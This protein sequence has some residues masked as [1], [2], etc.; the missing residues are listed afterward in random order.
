MFNVTTGYF[1]S[2]RAFDSMAD[3]DL[4]SPDNIAR[5]K[6]LL[7]K[8]IRAEPIERRLRHDQLTQHGLQDYDQWVAGL[9]EAGHLSAEEADILLQARAATARVVRVDE[10]EPGQLAPRVAMPEKVAASR[11]TVKKKSVAKKRA[12]AKKKRVQGTAIK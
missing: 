2:Q 7:H 10:F 6:R 1:L 11:R 5:Q 3:G 8:V 9:R 12:A 4:T